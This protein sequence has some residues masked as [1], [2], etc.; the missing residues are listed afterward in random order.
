LHTNNKSKQHQTNAEHDRLNN[1][2]GGRSTDGTQSCLF[3]LYEKF[4]VLS[5]RNC[6]HVL[7]SYQNDNNVMTS[8]E[9]GV[10]R[11]PCASAWDLHCAHVHLP[12]FTLLASNIDYL[13]SSSELYPL[14]VILLTYLPLTRCVTPSDCAHRTIQSVERC[15]LQ[16]KILNVIIQF[17]HNYLSNK[18]YIDCQLISNHK[19]ATVLK[20]LITFNEKLFINY[21]SLVF[22][23]LMYYKI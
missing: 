6:I 3:A 14:Y 9:Q 22:G 19:T 1:K 23:I 5:V 2:T 20:I 18:N 7:V 17:N 8:H 13:A 10:N 11:E 12:Q 4:V 16:F 21:F 15:A